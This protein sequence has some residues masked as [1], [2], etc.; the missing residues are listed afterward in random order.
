MQTLRASAS[1]VSQ[2][3]N[4]PDL[5]PQIGGPGI[6]S[7]CS[8]GELVTLEFERRHRIASQLERF[9]AESFVRGHTRR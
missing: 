6:D 2:V 3:W 8:Q 7:G 1:R 9:F 4:L 5:L